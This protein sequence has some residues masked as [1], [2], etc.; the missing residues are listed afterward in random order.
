MYSAHGIS[1]AVHAAA[2]ERSLHVID[3]TCPLVRKF[4]W[5]RA[6][7]PE[8]GYSIV[9]IGHRDHDE[10]V[11]TLGE[12]PDHITLVETVEDVDRLELPDPD[13]VAYLTQ[14]TLSVDEAN[15][16]INRLW[17]RYPN[18]PSVRIRKT[19]ATP[20]KT[21]RKPSKRGCP[22]RRRAGLWQQ[23]QLEQ[24]PADRGSRR[25][26]GR[27]TTWS[28]TSRRSILPGFEGTRPC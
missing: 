26:P 20:L 28:T 27:P 1:P 8:L 7:S 14:T 15:V 22:G 5:S 21:A 19:S 16:L 6:D 18:W 12:A 4:T 2:S 13:K 3:A 11:G 24:H 10:V 23:E 9:L 25:S 17:Q